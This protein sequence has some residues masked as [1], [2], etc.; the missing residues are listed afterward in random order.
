MASKSINVSDFRKEIG[1]SLSADKLTYSFNE[2]VGTN[3]HGVKTFYNII[4]RLVYEAGVK[5]PD[6][7]GDNIGDK[8]I[9]IEDSY[10]DSKTTLP[11]SP[12][13][14]PAVA[15]I[16]VLSKIGTDGKIKKSPPTY[17][18]VGKNIGKSNQTN[19][20]TQGL[21][22]ALSKYNKQNAL[23]ASTADEHNGIKLYPPMLAQSLD[24]DKLQFGTAESHEKYFIQRKLNGVRAV[25]A[26]DS[27]DSVIMYS[28]TRKIYPGFD[29][30]KA[31][32]IKVFKYFKAEYGIG[33][34]IDGEIYKHGESL[35][36]ISGTARNSSNS[37]TTDTT[38]EYHVYDIFVPDEPTM[39]QKLRLDHLET[40][41]DVFTFTNIKHVDYET[42]TTKEQLTD[43]YKTAL[44]DKFEGI[45]LRKDAPY[46]YSYNGYHCNNLLKIK[47]VNDAEYKIIGYTA[48]TVGKSEG[49]LMFELE[50][51]DKNNII[52]KFTINLGL[53]INE[54]KAL[55]AKMSEIEANG[56]S[57][58]ENNYAGKYLTVLYDEL[59]TDN[60]PVRARTD[61]IIIRDD[62]L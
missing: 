10:F 18:R 27:T 23:S 32:L 38:L 12:D 40:M 5:T 52:H 45:M 35:Q 19:A 51:V 26:L 46:V 4:V 7:N 8:F 20:F 33:I 6:E 54:R 31:E 22:D 62:M 59:S 48:G 42:V 44:E 61:G 11:I 37:N 15:W 58:Y 41:F 9:P 49:V 28:R 53:P 36:L 21:R 24:M 3:A 43:A 34:Y 47:P 16:K 29:N 39:L 60:V 2:I 1:G 14:T 13:L 57:H 17:V 30:I 56:K 55:F 50:A 25:A